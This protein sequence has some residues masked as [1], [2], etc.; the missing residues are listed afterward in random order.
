MDVHSLQFPQT[1]DACTI[2][3]FQASSNATSCNLC[4]SNTANGGR[5]MSSLESCMCRP[6]S[7]RRDGKPG[8]MCFDC[9]EGSVC[10]GESQ[11]PYAAQGFWGD[12][13]LVDLSEEDSD[14]AAHAIHRSSFHACTNKA[15]CTSNWTEAEYG[16]YLEEVEDPLGLVDAN[17]RSA[18]DELMHLVRSDPSRQCS[19]ETR[20]R[21]CSTCSLNYYS[22]GG[23]CLPCMK[24]YALFVVGCILAVFA[25]WYMINRCG[26]SLPSTP[27]PPPPPPNQPSPPGVGYTSR[28]KDHNANWTHWTANAPTTSG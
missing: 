16:S 23:K 28:V 13:G 19:V 17:D 10:Q 20:G 8:R 12:W 7:Y 9:P 15:Y 18:G 11:A 5:G 25:V 27:P 26:R 6:G 3:T 2:N 1:C 14:K 4:P 21:M 22:L 24:P